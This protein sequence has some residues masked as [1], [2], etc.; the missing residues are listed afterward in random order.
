MRVDGDRK[1][2]LA[3]IRA[4]LRPMAGSEGDEAG[5]AAVQ[6]D[7]SFIFRDVPEGNYR[8]Q[9]SSLPD[10]YYR[11]AADS[12]AEA[13]VVVS[14][15]HASTVEIRLDAGAGSVQGTVFKDKDNQQPLASATVVLIPDATRRSDSEYYR[16]AT[17]DRS[18]AF[19]LSS[20]PP[21]DYLLFVFEQI[22]RDAYMDPE[23]IQQNEELG[24][25]VRVEEG[26]SLNL[27]LQ[28]TIPSQDTS[29]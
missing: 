1:V 27:Q 5:S 24:K 7:G 23:F 6:A 21:G 17:S 25:P 9:L 3:R 15:G 20:V 19:R 18:G 14:H 28:P 11:K 2:A 13:G 26:S 16:V 29:H 10:G 22:E 12:A 8:V 4:A